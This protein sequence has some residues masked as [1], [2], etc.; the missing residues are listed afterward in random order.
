LIP[1]TH[2]ARASITDAA[3]E[4]AD[5]KRSERRESELFQA[6]TPTRKIKAAPRRA[7]NTPKGLNPPA[8]V[9]GRR[10]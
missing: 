1:C 3:P 9:S 2:K 5:Q 7:V 4:A 6:G 10:I 8:S